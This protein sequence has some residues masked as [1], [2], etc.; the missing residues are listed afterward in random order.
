M[1]PSSYGIFVYFPIARLLEAD[2]GETMT[3]CGTE[4]QS[5]PHSHTALDKASPVYRLHSSELF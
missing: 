3:P 1:L 5:N 2:T 4:E